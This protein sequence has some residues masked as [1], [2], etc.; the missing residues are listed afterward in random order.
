MAFTQA[1]LGQRSTKP[2]GTCFN[3]RLYSR[4]R[5]TT[6][7]SQRQTTTFVCQMLGFTA[8]GESMRQSNSLTAVIWEC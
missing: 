8:G 5:C 3:V 6:R 4:L 1:S 2:G 7:F